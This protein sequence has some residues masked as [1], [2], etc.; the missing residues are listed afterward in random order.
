MHAVVD[1]LRFDELPQE[2]NVRA[3]CV[4]LLDSV[5][6]VVMGLLCQKRAEVQKREEVIMFLSPR[7]SPALGFAMVYKYLFLLRPRG[8]SSSEE[9]NPGGEDG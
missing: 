3:D 7:A 2:C 9:L 4:S 5:T 1:S 6:F 8:I